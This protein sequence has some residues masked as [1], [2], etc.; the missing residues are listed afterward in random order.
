MIQNIREE[1]R[2]V[3]HEALDTAIRSVEV[4]NESMLI[5]VEISRSFKKANVIVQGQKRPFPL[6]KIELIIRS[7]RGKWEKQRTA[8]QFTKVESL[9][10]SSPIIFKM[11]FYCGPCLNP[12]QQIDVSKGS[13]GRVLN[14]DECNGAENPIMRSLGIQDGTKQEESAPKRA[15]DSKEA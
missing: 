14:P 13:R 10:H 6:S 11:R 4:S 9:R 7:L 1:I 12:S 8:L 2:K 5:L 3:T 15:D